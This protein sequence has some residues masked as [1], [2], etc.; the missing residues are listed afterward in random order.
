VT[1]YFADDGRLVA[2]ASNAASAAEVVGL[3]DGKEVGRWT[4][5][6]LTAPGESRPV[7]NQE[8]AIS[9][10]PGRHT[11]ELTNVGPDWVFIDL[12]RLLHARQADYP[13]GWSFPPQVVGSRNGERAIIYVCSP[14]IVYP[15]G[16]LRY[17]PPELNGQ[18]IH[19]SG[20]S[21]GARYSTDWYDAISAKPVAHAESAADSVGRLELKPPAYRE[22][23]VAVIAKE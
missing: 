6:A 4:L 23:L 20:W 13:D 15:A 2:H 7:V 19:L 1:A 8:L 11:I 10:P 22:D 17:R 14:W 5:G 18:T 16:A 9:V 21:K 12:L 3:I